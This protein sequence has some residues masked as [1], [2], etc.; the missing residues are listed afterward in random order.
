MSPETVESLIPVVRAQLLEEND[1]RLVKLNELNAPEVIIVNQVR[2]G[3]RI[4]AGKD[5]RITILSRR[6]RKLTASA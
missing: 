1:K 2:I 3:E 4:A 5:E 6:L